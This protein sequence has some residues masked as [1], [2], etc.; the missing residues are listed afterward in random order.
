MRPFSLL[1]TLLLL[2]GLFHHLTVSALPNSLLKISSSDSSSNDDPHKSHPINSIHSH[3]IP[4]EQTTRSLDEDQE[5]FDKLR[6]H[7]DLLH[8]QTAQIAATEASLQNPGKEQ[9]LALTPPPDFPQSL[10]GLDASKSSVTP[11][12]HPS[13]KNHDHS[14]DMK[15]AVKE[16]P[17]L[18]MIK[19]GK[20]GA[21]VVEENGQVL[22]YKLPLIDINNS[23]YVGRI[24]VG[25]PRYGTSP[26]YF[27]VIFDSGS[28]NLWINSD[29]CASHACLVHNRFH[30][31]WSR[32]YRSLAKD[33]RTV[34]SVRFGTGSID[35]F[36]ARDTF[37]LGPIVVKNQGFGQ[38]TREI[39][40]VFVSG[41]FDGILGLSFPSLSKSGFLPVFD[42]MMQQKLLT[43]NMFSLYY[44]ALP[45]QNSAIL[46]GAPARD[47]Y[48]GEL[49]WI[50]VSRPLYWEVGLI[51]IEYD[52]KSLGVCAKAHGHSQ[53]I[54]SPNDPHSRN[55]PPCKAV[56]DTG[57]S[58]LTGPSSAVATILRALHVHRD[59]TQ[60]QLLKPL[61]YV[62][63]DSKGEHRLTV[64]PDYYV[65]KSQRKRRRRIRRSLSNPYSALLDHK[66][67][68]QMPTHVEVLPKYCRAGFMAL[69]VP[70]PRGPLFILGDLFMR[71]YY[72]VFD[73][74][75]QRI[76]FAPS[77]PILTP[78]NPAG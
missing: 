11:A 4:L 12:S 3:F 65:L 60:T 70:E 57:T 76:G 74:D 20:R 22:E 30:P 64:E 78:T 46:L 2:N 19:Y 29:Q 73:R 35:G 10:M 47:L 1:I 43:D 40:Q 8:T 25:E 68:S 62:L 39:G 72:T 42:S 55:H 50:D 26:Q 17:Y 28:S 41:K 49:D 66:R 34:M 37:T 13:T 61:T 6:E 59:C 7:H 15:E 77:K 31:S 63:L 53:S 16:D 69:D 18:H 56:V 38:I 21:A 71:K 67:Q 32:S 52:G 23:Q 51:D 24:Q 58:L 75:R 14:I 54:V 9:G 45:V 5:F 44:T 36:L 33:R 27:N 48:T